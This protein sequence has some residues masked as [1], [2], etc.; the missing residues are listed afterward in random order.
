MK[1]MTDELI[2]L[3]EVEAVLKRIQLFDP[4]GIGARSLQECLCIQLNQF[5]AKTTPWL[6]ETKMR[7]ARAY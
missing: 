5:D 1:A 2:E 4:V 7:T 6:D 3:D